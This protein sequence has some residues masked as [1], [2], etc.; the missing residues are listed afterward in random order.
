MR[1][2]WRWWAVGLLAAAIFTLT[3]FSALILRRSYLE[4]YDRVHAQALASAHVVGG[5]IG[6]ILGASRQAFREIDRILGPDVSASAR[7][8]A[9]EIRQAIDA[10]PIRAMGWIVDANGT[11][12]FSTRADLPSLSIADRPYFEEL[13]SSRQP[14]TVTPL[15]VGR[16]SGENVF[17]VAYRLQREGRFAGAIMITFPASIMSDF[18]KTLDLGEG[19][20]VSVFRTDGALVV[21]YPPPDGP[22]NLSNYV[23]FT[24]YLPR[25]PEGTYDAVSP[26][27]GVARVVGYRK[28]ENEPLVA[29]ASIA[30][31]PHWAGFW[32][33][34][35]WMIA[36]LALLVMA[37]G[38]VSWA[39]FRML[40]RDEENQQAL[41]RALER[42]QLLL[43]EVNHRIKNNLQA[44]AGMLQLAPLDASTKQAMALRLDAMS[45]IHELAYRSDQYAEVAL[46]P[47]LSRLI[48]NL[49]RAFGTKVEI[50]SDLDPVSVDRDRAL[51]IG[52]LTNEILFNAF[53]HAFPD[54]RTGRIEITLKPV[55]TERVELVIRDNGVG[56]RPEPGGAGI[57]ARLIKGLVAQLDGEMQT[58]TADG[59]VV[60]L[61]FALRQ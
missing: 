7:I 30:V 15:I 13:K 11:P 49:R 26:A 22:M 43:Q 3:L 44:V 9:S 51:P 16:A 8:A 39:L 25:N 42:N 46:A 35:R 37:L 41:S 23:L 55:A 61:R 28:L 18:R 6:W 5:H 57:G 53:K 34:L 50:T 45:A 19:S 29:L 56:Y 60:R 47:Y 32:G 17:L 12:V 33:Q 27:D 21:R 1:T 36:I 10:M 31:A 58:E 38:A 24:D 20:T 48:E 54:G 4:T 52:L 59:T 40:R 2:S 14:L